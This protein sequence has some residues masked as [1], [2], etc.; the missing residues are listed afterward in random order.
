M[1][2]SIRAPARGATAL[3]AKVAEDAPFQ[4]ALPRGERPTPTARCIRCTKFQFALPRGERHLT[5]GNQRCRQ[6]FQFALPRGERLL[7]YSN[8]D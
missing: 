5:T 7:Q 4:F 2:V 3:E 6:A 8:D 1:A